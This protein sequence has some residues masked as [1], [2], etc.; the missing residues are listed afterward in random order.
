[1][2]RDEM[3]AN[4]A[5][6]R[7]KLAAMRAA[8]K[9]ITRKKKKAKTE[10]VYA[11]NPVKKSRKT[12]DKFVVKVT[13]KNKKVGYLT[14]SQSLDTEVKKAAKVSRTAAENY[15]KSFFAANK[16]H[17]SRVEVCALKKA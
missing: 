15:A 7:A 3:L 9:K 2:T 14:P 16:R 5:K 8:G 11:K 1:M 17:L 13:L 10:K 4:L 12:A 6:G